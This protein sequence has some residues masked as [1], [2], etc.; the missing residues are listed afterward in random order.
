MHCDA[1]LKARVA[2]EQLLEELDRVGKR[3]ARL[4][5]VSLAPLCNGKAPHVRALPVEQLDQASLAARIGG[6]AGNCLMR[7]RGVALLASIE[8]NA[9]L[10]QLDRAFGGS[11]ASGEALSDGFPRSADLLLSRIE[12]R[13]AAQLAVALGNRVEPVRRESD[14]AELDAFAPD[15]RLAILAIEVAPADARPWEI[16]LACP[17]DRL[18]ELLGHQPGQEQGREARAPASPLDQPFADLP[19]FLEARLV[20]M[21]MRL[22]AL[23]R[24]EPGAVL[25]IAVAR[26][27]PLCIGTRTI[28]VGT[29]GEADDRVALSI[30]Q[31]HIRKDTP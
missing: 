31:S 26:A 21:R 30:S 24:L 9:V 4:L 8:G 3:F 13:I 10:A 16:T 20:D 19:L 7:C 1:L 5:P 27:V 28:A 29:L 14:Y 22:S 6:L 23:A 25:P 18:G 17:L 11:G 12:S 2:P 15:A